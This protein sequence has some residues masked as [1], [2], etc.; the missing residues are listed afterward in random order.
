VIQFIRGRYRRLDDQSGF[1][2]IEMVVV[3][4]ILGIVLA[5]VQQATLTAFK[6][7]G[8]NATRL[9]QAQQA[10]S[11]IE[12]MSKVLR[13]AVLPSQ[14]LGSCTLCDVSAFLQG[15]PNSVSFYANVNNPNNTIGP[16]K[17]TYAVNPADPTGKLVEIIQQ[18]DAHAVNDTNYQYCDIALP[19]CLTDKTRVVAY[20]VTGLATL[21]TYY[22]KNGAV[23][24]AVP[25]LDANELTEVDSMDILLTIK[26]TKTVKGTTLTQRVALPNADSVVDNTIVTP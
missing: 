9:D 7:V 20:G 14:L 13:T 21:F 11:G 1:T 24:N 25:P 23:L 19:S 18:P 16:S 6:D 3:I 15:T 8:S 4:G 5:I 26:R 2:L 17:A 10:K 12:S 22:D